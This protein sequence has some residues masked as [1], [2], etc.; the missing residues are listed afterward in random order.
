MATELDVAK[1]GADTS[2]VIS[3]PEDSSA[4]LNQ[5]QKAPE[6]KT[7]EEVDPDDDESGHK[8]MKR[9]RSEATAFSPKSALGNTL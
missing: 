6:T 3:A 9:A 1:T 7:G 4:S 2:H 8:P 5:K